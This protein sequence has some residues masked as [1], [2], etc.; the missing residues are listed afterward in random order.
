MDSEWNLGQGTVKT[1]P[2]ILLKSLSSFF[3]ISLDS[4]IHHCSRIK[5]RPHQRPPQERDGGHAAPVLI[6]DV[7]V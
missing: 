1:P 5:P 6:L 7:R 2:S 4:A 3:L